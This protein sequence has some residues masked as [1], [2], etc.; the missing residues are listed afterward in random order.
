MRRQRLGPGQHTDGGGCNRHTCHESEQVEAC[1]RLPR[2]SGRGRNERFALVRT[3]WPPAFRMMAMMPVS[4]LEMSV[5]ANRSS[6][7]ETDRQQAYCQPLQ[8]CDG[9]GTYS[10]IGGCDRNASL[11]TCSSRPT[12]GAPHAGGGTMWPPT[13][14]H[15]DLCKRTVAGMHGSWQLN[16]DV[17]P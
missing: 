9:L 11:S 17:P 2:Q 5:T 6:S 7:K 14:H 10:S 3:W 16:D 12:R 4:S 8:A 1:W 15:E 13:P